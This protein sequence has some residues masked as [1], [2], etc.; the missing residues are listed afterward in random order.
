VNRTGKFN[1]H[2][3]PDLKSKHH[4]LPTYCIYVFIMVLTLTRF[5]PCIRDS[6]GAQVWCTD[7]SKSNK[8]TGAGVFRWG[9]GRGHSFSLALN[10]TVFQAEV[11]AIR[12]CIMENQEKLYT[13]RNSCIIS[14]SQA[15]IK[16]LD[17][18]HI[19]SKLVWDC[20]QSLTKQAERNRILLIWVPGHMGIDGNK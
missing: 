8:D 4:I 5:S 10:T 11:Y 9:S 14:D 20:H 12:A 18:F 6:A 15:A 7:G 16:A 3:S 17:S 2:V 1:L 19:N 13:G